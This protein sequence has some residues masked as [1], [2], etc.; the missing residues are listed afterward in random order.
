[1]TV[2]AT[3]WN[4]RNDTAPSMTIALLLTV[5]QWSKSSSNRNK[6]RKKYLNN[7]GTIFQVQRGEVKG[8]KFLATVTMKASVL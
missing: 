6:G 8:V 3:Q 1:M 5:L 7:V 4:N 2:G